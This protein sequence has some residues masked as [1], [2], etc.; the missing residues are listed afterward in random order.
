MKNKFKF[1]AAFYVALSLITVRLQAQLSGVYTINQTIAA[2]PTN[3]VSFTSL[4][5]ALTASGVSAPVTV[6]VVTGTGPYT[7]QANFG[8]IVGTSGTNTI[9]INGNGNTLTFNATVSTAP[10]TL[11]LSGADYMFVNNLNVVGTNATYALVLHLYNQSDNNNFYNCTFT[12][13]LLATAVATS[14][15]SLSGSNNNA[16]TVGNSGNNNVW[17][18]CTMSGGYY[19]TT[20][21]GNSSAPN[22]NNQVINCN[23]VDFYIYGCYNYYT[24]GTLWRG[25]TIERVNRTNPT[26]GYGFYLTTGVTGITMEKNRIRKMFDGVQP[27]TG[28]CY[29]FY[30]LSGGTAL[31]VN[32]IRNNVISDI[33]CNGTIYGIYDPGY[34]YYD[35]Y[36]NTISIDDVNAT[37]GTSYAIYCSGNTA[38]NIKNNIITMNRGG[39]GTKYCLYYAS[40]TGITSNNNMLYNAGTTGIN[41]VGYYNAIFNT[42]AQWK[43]A[44]GWDLASQSADPLYTSTVTGNYMPSEPTINNMG[45]PLG[46]A[47]DIMNLS[48]NLP[49]PDAGAYEFFNTQCTGTPSSNTVTVPTNIVCPSAISSLGLANT[50]TVNG[51]NY[52]WGFSTGSALGPFTAISGATLASLMTSTLASSTWYTFTVSCVNGGSSV[53]A[54]SGQVQIATTVTNSVPYYEGFEGILNNN[55]LPNCSWL[56]NNKNAQTRTNSNTNNQIPNT[57]SKF[58]SVYGYNLANTSY[59]WTNGIQLHAGV[60]YS[61]SMF[62]TTEYYGYTNFAELSILLGTTQSTNGLSPIAVQTG[63]VMSPIYK[64]LANTF[65]VATSGIYYVAIKVQSTAGSFAYYLSWDDLS[66]TIPCELNPTNITLTGTTASTLCSGQALNLTANGA[67]TYTWS[68]GVNTATISDVPTSNSSYVVMGTNTLTGCVSTVVKNVILKPTPVV[69]VYAFSPNICEGTSTNLNATG[70]AS[71]TWS[72]GGFGPVVTVSPLANTIYTVVGSN[73]WGCVGMSTQM[74]NVNPAPN[75][76]ATN[77]PSTSCPGDNITFTGSGAATYT[78]MSNT[79]YAVGSP[80]TIL[81]PASSLIYSV[82]GTDANG[83]KKTISIVQQVVT[84]T[85]INT[86]SGSIK[87]L[88]VYPNPT[89]GAFV[90]ELIN[91]LNKTIEV[92]DV[93]GRVV[94]TV[95]TMN[96]QIDMNINILSNGVYYIKVKSDNAVGVLKIVKD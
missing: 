7:Q 61:A 52:Q 10:H 58:A 70:A 47:Q 50:Y 68:T 19:G 3:F 31:N 8:V 34:N 71:Y 27:S 66:I 93:T 94:M 67:N 21:V 79:N 90:V 42:L 65:S 76:A 72:N 48:R 49:A 15:V 40:A 78:W 1:I 41:G 96:D 82:T 64:Q 29:A 55:D 56:I 54:T 25:N 51:L 73:S 39:T 77:V 24:T 12:A 81:S 2:S 32:T 84:C 9:T 74:I 5:A 86:Q 80:V 6:N 28:S 95:S 4:A 69:S 43:T 17:E 60:T 62:Y 22:T 57:G 46:V 83:C 13:P 75:V 18:N 16:T 44:N 85:G 20:I 35:I 37:G 59:Y 14:P 88:S 53:T 45:E 11:M 26:T 38:I 89:S 30:L 87:N 63:P 92:T 33:R 36:H 23:I 91:G